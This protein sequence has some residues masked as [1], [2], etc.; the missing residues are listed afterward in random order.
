MVTAALGFFGEGGG[1][2]VKI[3]GGWDLDP[4]ENKRP[5]TLF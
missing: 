3:C 4:L 2:R 1:G 5:K